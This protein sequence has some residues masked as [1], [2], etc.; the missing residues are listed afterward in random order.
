[1]QQESEAHIRTLA[2]GPKANASVQRLPELINAWRA[3]DSETL[4]A[5]FVS[6][7][8]GIPAISAFVL[9]SLGQ[10]NLEFLTSQILD[11][12]APT[13]TVWAIADA[14]LLFDPAEVTRFTVRRMR[15]NPAAVARC[16]H[17]RQ[18]R[19][20]TLKVTR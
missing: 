6:K 19:I 20:A 5:M 3:A 4:K 8:E 2:S 16:L 17:Y 9:S 15:Q 14:L 18:A 12:S 11:P 7:E 13:D 1:M 10:Q